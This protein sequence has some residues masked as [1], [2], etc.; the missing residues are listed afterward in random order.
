M[1]TMHMQTPVQEPSP[2][3]PPPNPSPDIVPHPA[4]PEIHQPE[5]PIPTIPPEIEPDKQ[6]NPDPQKHEINAEENQEKILNESD[7]VV[8]GREEVLQK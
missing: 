8:N 6:I 7:E 3:P 2:A 5:I 4:Q 1:K